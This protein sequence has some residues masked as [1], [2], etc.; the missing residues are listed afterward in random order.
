MFGK[1]S[2]SFW[3]WPIGGTVNTENVYLT[4]WTEKL[5]AA[6]GFLSHHQERGDRVLTILRVLNYDSYILP[7]QTTLWRQ[8]KWSDILWWFFFNF[9]SVL[10]LQCSTPSNFGVWRSPSSHL[11]IA[12]AP[13]P[14][15]SP[16]AWCAL[17][18]KREARTPVRYFHTVTQKIEYGLVVCFLCKKEKIEHDEIMHWINYFSLLLCS[19]WLRRSSGVQRNPAGYCLLGLWLR[20]ARPTR[21]LHQSL[22]SDALDWRYSRQIQLDCDLPSQHYMREGKPERDWRQEVVEVGGVRKKCSG[23]VPEREPQGVTA[24]KREEGRCEMFL[25]RAE[26]IKSNKFCDASVCL[27]LLTI[28]QSRNRSL[29]RYLRVTVQLFWIF[30][31]RVSGDICS[32]TITG[33][34]S[35]RMSFF[36]RPTELTAYDFHQNETYELTQTA[37]V[38]YYNKWIAFSIRNTSN[39]R[40]FCHSFSFL[41]VH[42]HWPHFDFLSPEC[43]NL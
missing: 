31:F 16:T 43:R 22:R 38:I 19:G 27:L 4:W 41:C 23:R 42:E 11:R 10:F 36:L 35:M 29:C 34:V 2:V 39:I 1:R 3:A 5:I 17:D 8:V 33:I 37:A 28:L 25:V 12:I 13:T 20:S 15:W 40:W 9:F 14:A 21:R 26:S 7:L 6:G 24:E 30:W 18:T 32:K